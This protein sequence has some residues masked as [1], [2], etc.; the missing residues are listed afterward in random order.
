[1]P[2]QWVV[3]VGDRTSKR[4]SSEQLQRLF[5]LGKIPP[6]AMLSRDGDIWTTVDELLQRGA[7][8]SGIALSSGS[9]MC[10]RA[11]REQ[12]R[13]TLHCTCGWQR[14]VKAAET[15]VGKRARCPNC[16]RAVTISEAAGDHEVP[17]TAARGQDSAPCADTSPLA[18]SLP[19]ESVRQGPTGT[20][21]L[22][23]PAT[24]GDDNELAKGTAQR[25]L[26]GP[27]LA[28]LILDIQ[29]SL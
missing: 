17:A 16:S 25:R 26:K 3:R 14:H 5:N 20:R 22:P 7:E 23:Q 13:V 1:M 18:P 24:R 6:Q 19:R 9:R 11:F 28:L 12:V 10:D 21:E 2:T 27:S 8:A 15:N 29:F 4:L